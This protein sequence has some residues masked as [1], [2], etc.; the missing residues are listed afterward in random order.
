MIAV[1]DYHDVSL[2]QGLVT[3][4]EYGNA[5]PSAETVRLNIAGRE[6]T[7]QF[8]YTDAHESYWDMSTARN[9][10]RLMPMSEIRTYC[11]KV[12]R[13]KRK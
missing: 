13:N 3:E 2:L 7:L 4:D 6:I 11:T 12:L 9:V 1:N 8:L 5:V 10:K